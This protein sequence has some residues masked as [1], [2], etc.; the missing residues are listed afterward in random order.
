M[1]AAIERSSD[2]LVG[3]EQEMRRL[4]A[5]IRERKSQLIWGPADAGKTFLV[6]L[7]IAGLSAAD[8]HK[9]ICWSGA[10]SGRRVVAHFLSGLYWAGDPLVRGKVHADRAG[11]NT[12]DRWISRQSLLRLR[13]ILF[14]ATEREDYRF[15]VDHLPS[16]THKMASLLKEIMYRCK[17]PVYLTGRG[18]SQKEIGHAWSLYWADEYRIQLGPL[19]ELPARELLE[20]CIHKF[21]LGSLDLEGFRKDILHSSGHLPGA[22]VRMCELAADPRY[23]YGDQVKV[24]LLHVD[25]L[26]HGNAFSSSP[27]PGHAT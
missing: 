14:S 8:R 2:L 20:T 21:G 7:V 18:Y 16:P 1:M 12:L 6:Q 24:K 3:R 22:I 5:A 27:F 17:T 4:R 25:Y 11:E 23:H 10:G 19:T 13:G 26:L 9:C 15:F